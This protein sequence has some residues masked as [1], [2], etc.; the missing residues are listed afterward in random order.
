MPHFTL[1]YFMKNNIIKISLLFL[2]VIFYNSYGQNKVFKYDFNYKPNPSKDS[3]II[4]KTILDIKDRKLSI[5]RTE[6]ERRSDSLKALNG[7]GIGNKMRFED[8]F[9]IIKDLSDSKVLRSFKT[10]FSEIFFVKINERLNWIILP[11]KS[12]IGTFEVQKAKVKY[13]GRDWTAWFTTEIPIQ[14]GPY[15]F[16]GLPGLI[17]EISDD[18]NNFAF[19]LTEIKD[20]NEEI[21]YRSKGSEL[22]WDQ[23]KKLRE[24][25][26][27]D[28]LAR[29]KSMN[30]PYKKDDGFGNMVPV[31]MKQE[32][33]RMKK[34]IR[35]DNNPIE[36]NHKIDYK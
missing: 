3:V 25:Y 10:I 17:V 7:F 22:S 8:Q 32:S 24:S 4:E 13:G 26:Y 33:D 9:Y 29:I 21:H 35:E 5:F 28:P 27:S 6:Q 16:N 11:E 34:V 36:L 23:F 31:D 19:N 1:T 30:I 12:K 2:T 15:V 14:E 18:Q 20:L